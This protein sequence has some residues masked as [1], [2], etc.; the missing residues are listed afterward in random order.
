MFNFAETIK[1]KFPYNEKLGFYVKPH[2]P[3]KLLGKVLNNYTKISSPADV[4]ALYY[5]TTVFSSNNIV[6]TGTH[7]FAP[8][9][10]F[11]LE[12]I[13]SARANKNTLELMINQS[14]N[15]VSC[16]L[17]TQNEDAAQILAKFFED[18]VYTPRTE[19]LLATV[20]SYEQYPEA[21]R[22]WLLLRDEIMKTIDMLYEK[23]NEGKITL[24][25]FE[26]KKQELLSR[27]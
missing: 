23:F 1:K 7:L 10:S 14:G 27:L 18:L 9:N 8:K 22:N 13:R 6:L 2:L 15:T 3:A 11:L 24:L 19:S 5:Y 16:Q 4:V 26:E 12:D 20:N 21:E 17:S 25:E